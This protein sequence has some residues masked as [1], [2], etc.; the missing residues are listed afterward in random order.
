VDIMQTTCPHCQLLAT[1]LEEAKAHFGDKIAVLEV[2][3]PPDNQT[4]VSKY[5][6]ANKITVPVICDMGQMTASYFK[7]TPSTMQQVDVPHVFIID[8]Q[9]MIRNDFNYSASTKS[10][11][12]AAGLFKEIDKLL[13]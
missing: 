9:G 7:A 3:L 2:V 13:K 1:A 6:A 5:V 10:L 4:T 11:F 12:E 8:Q